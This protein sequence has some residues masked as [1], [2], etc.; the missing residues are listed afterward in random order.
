[1]QKPLSP[2]NEQMLK[3]F[4]R[5]GKTIRYVSEHYMPIKKH[6][7]YSEGVLNRIMPTINT[8][9]DY[10]NNVHYISNY[11]NNIKVTDINELHFS[12]YKSE[13]AKREKLMQTCIELTIFPPVGYLIDNNIYDI[14]AQDLEKLIFSEEIKNHCMEL[15]KDWKNI[16]G[17]KDIV[18][19][20]IDE[21][22]SNFFLNNNASVNLLIYA[23]LEWLFEKE[24]E[25][26]QPYKQYNKIKDN[27][28]LLFEELN[29]LNI[30]N[31]FIENNSYADTN[32][33]GIC[34]SRHSVHGRID[35][36]LSCLTNINLIFI[37][38]FIQ[39]W[40]IFDKIKGFA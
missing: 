34:F 17:D 29:L 3:D 16:F 21:I 39:D 1:M 26:L 5:I 35:L 19:R 14:E 25:N 30:Y 38:D 8:I 37:Y 31:H 27:L 11:L 2:L 10:M 6:I 15:I 23:L 7:E 20:Y 22:Q 36:L 4:N 40:F 12:M 33:E 13:F 28:K 18:N 32:K 9:S 24:I